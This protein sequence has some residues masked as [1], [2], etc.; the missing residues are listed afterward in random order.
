MENATRVYREERLL[1]SDVV[2][3]RKSEADIDSQWDLFIALLAHEEEFLATEDEIVTL[4]GEVFLASAS[5]GL[6]L[7]RHRQCD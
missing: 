5:P 4:C 1:H 2:G 6:G 7:L 3:V